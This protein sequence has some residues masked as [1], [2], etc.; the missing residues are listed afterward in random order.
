MDKS[1][2]GG[3]RRDLLFLVYDF[4]THVLHKRRFLLLHALLDERATNGAI[5]GNDTRSED[6]VRLLGLERAFRVLQ[7]T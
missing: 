2:N 6:F 1:M 7:T 4:R 5:A 3:P